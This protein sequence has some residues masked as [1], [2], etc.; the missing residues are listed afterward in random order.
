MKLSFRAF[1]KANGPR[2]NGREPWNAEELRHRGKG[3][4][5]SADLLPGCR[6]PELR[7]DDTPVGSYSPLGWSNCI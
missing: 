4:A 2:R 3:L 6:K 1:Q 7:D 5:R